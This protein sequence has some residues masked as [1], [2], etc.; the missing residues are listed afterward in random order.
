MESLHNK[1]Y[2]GWDQPMSFP[3]RILQFLR[4]VAG[5]ILPS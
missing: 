5:H 4:A 3:A 2:E 1:Y